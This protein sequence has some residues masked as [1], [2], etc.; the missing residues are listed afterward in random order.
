MNDYFPG[1]FRYTFDYVMFAFHAQARYA[2]GVCCL[3]VVCT[4]FERGLYVVR[5][6]LVRGSYVACTW[7]VLGLYVVRTW[8]V[9]G[10]YVVRR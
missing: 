7:F 4:W 6:W 9:R 10:S 2:R 5:T 1:E 3:D 8:L